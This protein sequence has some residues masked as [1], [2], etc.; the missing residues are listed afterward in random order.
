MK[1]V[2]LFQKSFAPA[3]FMRQGLGGWLE[4]PEILDDLMDSLER[5]AVFPERRTGFS[6]CASFCVIG[7]N[8]HT[9]VACSSIIW[10]IVCNRDAQNKERRGRRRLP[11]RAILGHSDDDFATRLATIGKR[12]PKNLVERVLG[13]KE[14]SSK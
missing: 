1:K 2:Y 14:P 5:A 13:F 11:I 9:V 8:A 7:L 4:G 10:R 6:V 12:V 3:G